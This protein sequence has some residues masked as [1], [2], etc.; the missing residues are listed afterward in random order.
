MYQDKQEKVPYS[1]LEPA[2]QGDDK[3]WELKDNASKAG[4]RFSYPLADYKLYGHFELGTNTNSDDQLFLKFVRPIW[5][6][7]LSGAACSKGNKMP[8]SKTMTILTAA[9]ALAHQYT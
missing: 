9:I 3:R 6:S 8:L 4:I 2:K 1:P 7:K 5:E